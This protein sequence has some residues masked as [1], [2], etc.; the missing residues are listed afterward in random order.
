MFI[1]R[2]FLALTA[3]P[4]S[5]TWLRYYID[6]NSVCLLGAVAAV[7]LLLIVIKAVWGARKSKRRLKRLELKQ[8]EKLTP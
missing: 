8:T 4:L 3:F 6:D 5:F 2:I 1:D 7:T